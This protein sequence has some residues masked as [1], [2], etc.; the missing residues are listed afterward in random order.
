METS[1]LVALAQVD[2]QGSTV[3]AKD[4]TNRATL[5]TPVMKEQALVTNEKGIGDPHVS[6]D[7]DDVI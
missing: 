3:H 4:T 1:L 5:R 2:R 6:C 7:D